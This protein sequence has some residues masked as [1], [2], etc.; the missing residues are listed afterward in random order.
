MEE[1]M[2]KFEWIVAVVVVTIY[3]LCVA[4]GVAISEGWS[5]TIW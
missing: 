5:W 3:G 2:D 1:P 4:L